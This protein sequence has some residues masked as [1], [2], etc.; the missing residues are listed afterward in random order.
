MTL[1]FEATPF[2]EKAVVDFRSLATGRKRAL[3]ASLRSA[4]VA[5]GRASENLELLFSGDVL[6]VTTGQQPGLFTG[7]MYTVYKALTAAAVAQLLSER[8]EEP[9]VPVFWVA[10]D[11]H[12]FAE[13]NHTYLLTAANEVERLSLRERPAEAPLTPLYREKVG[14]EV[15]ELLERLAKLTPETE[16]RPAVLEWL[17]RHYRPD[18][19]LDSAF[20]GAVAELV[21]DFGV[22]VFR[23]T[24][25]R[26]KQAMAPF[27]VRLLEMAPELDRAL[28]EQAEW[29]RNRGLQVPIEVGDGACMVMLECSLGRDR[30]I[31][32]DGYFIARRARERWSLSELIAMAEREA[33][34]FS[35]NVL[36]RPV[37]EAALLPTLVYVA[38]P[39]ERAYL[40]QCEPLYRA[41]GVAQ[42]VALAR[43][44]GRV[45]EKRVGK[46]LEKYGI[47]AED[48]QLPD[49]QLETRLVREEMPNQAQAA[50]GELRVVLQ[51]EY[52]RLEE[53]VKEIDPTLI[54]PVQSARNEALVA[55]QEL[56]KKIVHHLK[57]ENEILV[58][59]LAKAR[60]NL[61]PL[62]K[63]QERVFNV[64]P[65]LIRYGR[66]FLG[67][68]F[69][70]CKTHALATLGGDP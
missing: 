67:Q 21:G 7:P 32:E 20:S 47:T 37:M 33:V 58:S 39:A 3:D 68:A 8:L 46:V 24:D 53:A 1:V 15:E 13:A 26:A 5:S 45:V 64:I 61:F 35:P 66:E 59:Q 30:L 25:E 42:Q 29:L 38:G 22:V 50:L 18:S 2:A 40:R 9:V 56:E 17:R 23:A 62:G 34:R 55:S 57:R 52:G 10:G 16:F 12:D 6:C 4:C 36:A 69:A 19:D 54:K 31:L 41:L 27:F 65:Y 28:A 63:P 11:D 51:R 44:S 49:G 70:A 14:A 43:W 60:H 48:L